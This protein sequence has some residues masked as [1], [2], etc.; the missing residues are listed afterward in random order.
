MSPPSS[1]PLADGLRLFGPADDPP[2]PLDAGALLLPGWAAAEA[3]RWVQCVQ[4][5]VAQAPW[6][7]MRTPGGAS[8]SVATSNCGDWGWVSD[9]SG[10]AYR[11]TDPLSGQPWPAMPGWLSDQAGA[12]AAAAGYPGFVPDACLINR[13]APGARMS[14]H[15]DADERDASAPIV[16]ISLGLP[17][18]FLWGGLQRSDRVRRMQL[19]HGD[20]LV[21]GGASR[22]TFH[23]VSPLKD[24]LHPLLGSERWNL[25]FR[26][27]RALYMAPTLARFA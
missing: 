11:A 5:V 10:Y 17:A 23:G 27:A 25:T 9:A 19:E 6:R 8:M 4:A 7:V 22:M 14:L 18:T 3:T 21:W 12:A 26:M 15:R 2:I 16:S 20:V 13:Y 1:A 24:G